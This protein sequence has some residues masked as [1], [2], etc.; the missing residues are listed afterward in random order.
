[1]EEKTIDLFATTE[2][3]TPEK[4]GNQAEQPNESEEFDTEVRES[5]ESA[6]ENEESAE[7]N[8]ADDTKL[9]PQE[10]FFW[11]RLEEMASEDEFLATAMTKPDKSIRECFDYMEMLAKKKVTKQSGAQCVAVEGTEMLG[12]AKHYYI[13]SKEA[14]DAEL[15]PKPKALPKS[16]AKSATKS[17]G[18]N[19]EKKIHKNPLLESIAKAAAEKKEE[20]KENKPKIVVTK[21]GVKIETAKNGERTTS[22]ERNGQTFTMTELSLF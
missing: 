9:T 20:S 21:D 4:S 5:T 8:K 7:E 19:E 18:K 11:A 14:I 10:E 16:A 15:H 22:I 17:A 13:E 12:W 2:V 3:E 6:E 1:M